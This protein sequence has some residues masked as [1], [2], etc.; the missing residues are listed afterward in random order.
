MAIGLYDEYYPNCHSSFRRSINSA[1]I[2]KSRDRRAFLEGV[3]IGSLRNLGSLRSIGNLGSR[4]AYGLGKIGSL[5]YFESLEE[6]SD[7][8]AYPCRWLLLL[9]ATPFDA[10]SYTYLYIGY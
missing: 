9:W 8:R 7:R 10:V 5:G 1:Q 3:G 2:E 6:F 4:T